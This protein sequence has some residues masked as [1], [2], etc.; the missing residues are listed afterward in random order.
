MRHQVAIRFPASGLIVQIRIG[1]LSA[2]FSLCSIPCALMIPMACSASSIHTAATRRTLRTTVNAPDAFGHEKGWLAPGVRKVRA[3]VG[4]GVR[5]RTWGVLI[6]AQQNHPTQK[7]HSRRPH[8]VTKEHGDGQAGGSH[9]RRY[10]C[11]VGIRAMATVTAK[12]GSHGRHVRRGST[13]T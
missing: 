11:R 6:E 4:A 12:D 5:A 13:V 7:I 1:H 10:S 8:G 2:A 9:G 3:H